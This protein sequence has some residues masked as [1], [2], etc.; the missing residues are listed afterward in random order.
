VWGGG[1]PGAED[2]AGAGAP[3]RTTDG[4]PCIICVRGLAGAAEGA[5]PTDGTAA[6]GAAEGA[7]EAPTDLGFA[8]LGMTCVPGIFLGSTALG[9]PAPGTGALGTGAL[10]AAADDSAAP[11]AASNAPRWDMTLLTASGE[12]C[13]AA[14]AL[15]GLRWD[16]AAPPPPADGGGP[17]CASTLLPGIAVCANGLTDGAGAS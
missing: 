7:A 4:A 1:A 5:G 6:E 13:D 2:G 8:T 17:Y 10:A 9:T 14:M 15:G 16:G 11:A 12:T 3:G